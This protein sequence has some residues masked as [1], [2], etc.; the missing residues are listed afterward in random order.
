MLNTLSSTMHL[1]AIDNV[2]IALCGNPAGHG[3]A[4]SRRDSEPA[5]SARP[6]GG[7][8]A[9]IAKGD[10]ILRYGQVIGFAS[11]D[12]APGDHVHVQNCEIHAFARDPAFGVDAHPTDYIQ[13]Q[14]TFQGIIRA[15]GRVATRNYIGILTSVNCSAGTARYVA[16]AFRRNP[17]TGDDGLLARLPQCRRRHCPDAQDRLRHGDRR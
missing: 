7:A 3:A 9:A 2:A 12:I 16:E 13:P 1:N 10:P 17:I 11:R 8:I 5:H 4:G 6:Q 14:A 15:D